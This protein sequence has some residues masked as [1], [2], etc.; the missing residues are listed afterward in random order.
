MKQQPDGTWKIIVDH[1]F[2]AE[3]GLVVTS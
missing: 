1:A 3:A 2:G